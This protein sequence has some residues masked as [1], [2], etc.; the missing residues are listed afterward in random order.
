MIMTALGYRPIWQTG[1]NA[2]YD[3]A[4][5]GYVTIDIA[6]NRWYCPELDRGGKAGSLVALLKGSTV[7][8]AEDWIAEVFLDGA[9]VEEN[10]TEA[11][12]GIAGKDYATI[13]RCGALTSRNLIRILERQRI[14][15]D[16]A[17]R[18]LLEV[19][20]C[21]RDNGTAGY[22]CGIR[23]ESGGYGIIDRIGR[24]CNIGPS[25]ISILPCA[26]GKSERCLVF[27]GILDFLSFA[28]VNGELS[29]DVIIIFSS[30]LVRQVEPIGKRY[31]ECHYYVPNTRAKDLTIPLM[32]TYFGTLVDMS[33]SYADFRNYHAWHLAKG[34]KE[35]A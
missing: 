29:D 20:Y 15:H 25:D 13:T 18:Y 26:E 27:V 24:P 3:I 22:G 1:T 10:A 31:L 30:A 17:S 2:G 28:A 14:P 6:H 19:A 11:A 7:E 12:G 32:R 5:V 21:S 34:P 35:D 8:A 33:Q 23:N 9:E 16:I 4:E